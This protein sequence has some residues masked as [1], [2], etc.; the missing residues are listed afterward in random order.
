[1]IIFHDQ[2]SFIKFYTSCFFASLSFS[3]KIQKHLSG[4][5]LQNRL[6]KYFARFTGNHLCWS[7]HLAIKFQPSSLQLFKKE[8][9][10]KIFS[11]EFC[12]IFKD[13]FFKNTLERLLLKF[14]EYLFL[15]SFCFFW[16]ICFAK[17][18]SQNFII[19]LRNKDFILLLFVSNLWSIAFL[20]TAGVLFSCSFAASFQETK[21]PMIE[22]V[23]NKIC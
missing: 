11:C 6:L 8:T 22:S 7:L 3:K 21:I 4:D 1:M 13:Y 5:V 15:E 12:E 16:Q 10:T 17:H 19:I 14:G 2:Q 18:N 9:L 23:L 20:K